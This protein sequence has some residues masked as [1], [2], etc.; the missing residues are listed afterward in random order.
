MRFLLCWSNETVLTLGS[1]SCPQSQGRR[2]WP[3]APGPI[4]G[5]CDARLAPQDALESPS[6]PVDGD[7]DGVFAPAAGAGRG[8][9][10][11]PSRPTGRGTA[12][13]PDVVQGRPRATGT[14]PLA[15]PPPAAGGG[16]GGGVTA[17]AEFRPRAPLRF[18]EQSRLLV[19]GLLDGGA[20]IAGQAVVECVPL[21][22]G[23]YVLFANNPIWRG[24]TIG[25]YFMVFNVMLSYDSPGAGR[26]PSLAGGGR[27]GQ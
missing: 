12:D 11:G 25:S 7:L 17:P 13:D 4:D 27:G 16:R 23:H 18:D 26:A 20:D 10:P 24:S 21:E 14:E 3:T 22:K 8:G 19:S 1:R 6:Q 9:G 2:R 15:G 5:R